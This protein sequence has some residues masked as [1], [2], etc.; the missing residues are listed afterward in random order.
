[1]FIENSSLCLCSILWWKKNPILL[2][3]KASQNSKNLGYVGGRS[4]EESS[5]CSEHG[6]HVHKLSFQS[7]VD[8]LHCLHYTSCLH[9]QNTRKLT[10]QNWS[11]STSK[12]SAQREVEMRWRH[13]D[14]WG[15]ELFTLLCAKQLR[16]VPFYCINIGLGR[17]MRDSTLFYF[18][19]STTWKVTEIKS[20]FENLLY[21]DVY[22]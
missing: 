10:L 2:E 22:L 8:V 4:G 15:F 21:V 17:G 7:P 1:M 18:P 19:V 5:F 20:S 9:Y 12:L 6:W 13:T 3:V 11:S 14:W 16:F